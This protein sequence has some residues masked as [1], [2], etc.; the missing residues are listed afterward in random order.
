MVEPKSD[1][2]DDDSG[3]EEEEKQMTLEEKNALLLTA[4]KEN[5]YDGVHEALR[6]GADP[7]CEE[8]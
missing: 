4:V 3:S 6:V 2:G 7:N 1:S 5:D 8:N